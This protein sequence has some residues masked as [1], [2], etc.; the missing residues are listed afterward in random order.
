MQSLVAPCADFVHSG[1]QQRLPPPCALHKLVAPAAALGQSGILQRRPPPWA[2]Q[3]AVVPCAPAYIKGELFH[4]YVHS[5]HID[6]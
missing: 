3:S 5:L 6:N 2:V 1:M 4:M